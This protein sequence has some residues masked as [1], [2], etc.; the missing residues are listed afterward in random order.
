MVNARRVT[1][2]VTV[3]VAFY[4]IVL[5]DRA[6]LMIRDGRPAFVLLGIGVLLLPLVGVW[7]IAAE[8]RFGRATE[9]L[10]RELAAADQLP[11]DELPRRPSGRVDRA[12]ADAVFA[13]VRAE[14][15][16]APEDWRGW[17]RLAVA[18]GDAGDSTRG[19]RAMRHAI[20]LR[21]RLLK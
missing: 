12:A 4:A 9:R 20:A 17:Y 14:V 5:G 8:L 2:L 6:W 21:A 7:V 18:Y 11:A 3:L 1:V 10:A 16:A 15:E 13:R 19:R